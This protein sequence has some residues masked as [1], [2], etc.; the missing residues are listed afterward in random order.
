MQDQTP[1]RLREKP[2][3]LIHQLSTAAHRLLVERLAAA[4]ARG[5]HYRVLAALAEFGASSQA[6]LGR[7]A[8]MDRSDV[9]AV[10]NEL[11]DLGHAER[12]ADQA[13][14]R[15][16]VITITPEGLARL[17]ELDRVLDGLQDELLAPLP[18]AERSQLT[19]LLERVLDHHAAPDQL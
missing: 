13:D 10:V 2:S 19:T 5:Y 4:G 8:L 6:D 18:P 9:V 16:N 11:A 15:R 7:R 3:W 14:R 12:A 17:G 1:A